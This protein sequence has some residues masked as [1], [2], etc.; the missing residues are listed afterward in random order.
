MNKVIYLAG[1]CFWGVEAYFSKLKG[2]IDAESGYANGLSEK[3]KYYSLSKTMHAETVKVTYDPNQ[4]SLEELL[5]H[6]FRI[7][8]P[9][10]L[11]KQGNDVGTQYRTGVYYTDINDRKVIE[12]VFIEYKKQYDEFYVELEEL[13]NYMTAEDYHQDYLEKNPTGYCHINLN[14]DF[15]LSEKE[16]EF[17]NLIRKE[18]ALDELSLNVLKYSATERPHTSEFNDEHRKG[19]YVEKITGE[20]LFASNT[21]FNAGCGWPSFAA[22]INSKAVEYKADYSHNMHRVEVRSKTGDN[23]LGHVFNDGPKEMG[24]LRYCINGAA[25][26]FI[27][28]EEMDAKGYSEYKKLLD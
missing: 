25:I 9:D 1:G 16:K 11:N 18:L 26:E 12:L 6:Y 21:K 28:L 20:V 17:V 3:T 24:G 23:H 5:V 2:V 13:K 4:I 7:I 15:N 8:H 27:P 10:S 19:I 14:V 22:P